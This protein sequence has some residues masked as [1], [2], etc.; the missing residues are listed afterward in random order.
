MKKCGS[1]NES[2]KYMC[3]KEIERCAQKALLILDSI[4]HIIGGQQMSSL[5]MKQPLTFMT[6]IPFIGGPRIIS[7]NVVALI[8]IH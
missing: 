8:C 7:R 3:L 6:D 2:L 1:R 4:F 5:R